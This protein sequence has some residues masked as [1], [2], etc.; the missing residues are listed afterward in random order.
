MSFFR[1]PLVGAA[2]RRA[3][4]GVGLLALV[5]FAL[6]FVGPAELSDAEVEFQS[7]SALVRTG[8]LAL[9]G[10]PEADLI[11]V[12]ALA[13]GEG[14]ERLHVRVVGEGDEARVYGRHGV[15]QVLVAVP[16]YVLGRLAALAAPG[17]EEEGVRRAYDG[18]AA[19]ESLAHLAVGLRNPLLGAATVWLVAMCALRLGV[20]RGRA[21]AAAGALAFTTYLWPQARSS[22]SDV[23]ATFF[24]F[25]AFHLV[26]VAREQLDRLEMPRWYVPLGIG[27][28]LA[29]AFLSRVA[30]APACVV[31][32]AVGEIVLRI[33][34]R[35]IAASRWALRGGKG[36]TPERAMALALAP[37]L[38]GFAAFVGANLARFGVPFDS[39]Y[40][41]VVQGEVFRGDPF[42]G[43]LGLWVSPGRGLLVMAPLLL[44]APFGL[45]R[46]LVEGERLVVGAIVA[47]VV[48]VSVPASFVEGW[49]GDVTYGPRYL[50]PILPFLWVFVAL[51]L[52]EANRR[53]WLDRV[54]VALGVAGTVVAL[55][56]VVVD[57]RTHDDLARQAARIA[58]PTAA[59]LGLPEV[60]A[61]HALE[62]A[63]FEATLWD[64]RFAAPLSHWRI[65]RHRVAGL[66]ERFPVS[67]V[68]FLDDPA[69]VEP[70]RERAQEFRHF[71]W[72]EFIRRFDGPGAV[73]IGVAA[74]L[75]LVAIVSLVRGLDRTSFE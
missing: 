47:V 75:V 14:A 18:A 48:V 45:R 2:D 68:F 37:L 11:R 9:G 21:V 70:L 35:R 72:R 1:R 53:R 30:V 12:E 51:G 3:A 73:P 66:G 59:S 17:L 56:G 57:H 6:T 22:L 15:G 39:G 71:G 74:L 49:H 65:F 44:L 36:V 25:A 33:G 38:C 8:A 16:F 4:A 5:L 41:S 42:T 69:E 67:E 60:T 32:A 50:L 64:R 28:A 63:R 62:A 31:V 19:S 54:A 26:L 55:G 24:L 43:A 23:Q 29:M 13:R 46:A 40:G 58:W 7:T 61:P 10:T 34:S 52:Q 27:A 20:G